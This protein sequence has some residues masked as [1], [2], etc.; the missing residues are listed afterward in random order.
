MKQFDVAVIGGGPGG[1]TAAIR[2]S[3]LGLKVICIEKS[4]SMGGTCL[5]VGC[6]PSK[7]LLNYSEKYKEIKNNIYSYAGITTEAKLDF[8]LM[9]KN[10]D[11]VV[12]KLC[13]GVS[14]LLEKNKVHREYSSAKI[15]SKNVILLSNGNKITAKNIIIATGSEPISIPNIAF[16]EKRILSST[17]ALGLSYIPKTITVIGGGYIGLE[18]GSVYNNL[19]SKVKVIEYASSIAPALDKEVRDTLF[20]SL[21]KQGLEF[22]LSSKNLQQ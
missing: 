14:G 5:N 9:Q 19:G 1:Y 13:N 3:Q 15:I 11:N 16:D 21:K 2:A 17:G 8:S 7:A 12:S 6:I 10:K 18:L 20:S 22:S 4:K